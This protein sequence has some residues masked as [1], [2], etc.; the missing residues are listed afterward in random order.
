MEREVVVVP[1]AG[2]LLR[3]Q[4][5]RNTRLVRRVQAARLAART[6]DFMPCIDTPDRS[7]SMVGRDPHRQRCVTRR[8]TGDA[9]KYE[10]CGRNGGRCY[11]RATLN[12][13]DTRAAVTRG[14][15]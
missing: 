13:S 4:P 11:W 6:E 10:L 8:A 9:V 14:P 12:N 2:L 5:A 7:Y 15:K 1:S 3:P